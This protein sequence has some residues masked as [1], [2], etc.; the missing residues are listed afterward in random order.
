MNKDYTDASNVLKVSPSSNQILEIFDVG[1]GPTSLL[2]YNDDIY[3]ARTFYDSSWNAYYGTSK[4]TNDLI[5][6]ITK[7]DYG[8]GIVCGGSVNMFYN[9]PYRSHDGGIAKL[10]TDLSIDFESQIGNYAPSN[11]YTVKTLRDKVYIGTTDGFL[12]IIDS[13]SNEIKSLSVGDFPGD[14]EFWYKN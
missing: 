13:N 3:V 12:K 4:I 11:V 8:N 1:K 7:I 14:I 10:N 9:R 6:D 2:K 5:D